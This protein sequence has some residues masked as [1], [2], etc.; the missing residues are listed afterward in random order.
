MSEAAPRLAGVELYFEDLPAATEFYTHVLGLGV[1]EARPNHHARLDTTPAFVCLERKGV[2]DY[3]SADKAVV[4]LEVPDLGAAVERIGRRRFARIA[5][6]GREPWA[7]LP[8][9]EGHTVMLVKRPGDAEEPRLAAWSTSSRVSEY[10]VE[11]IPARLWRATIPGIPT[12]TVRSIAAHLHNARCRWVKTLGSEHGIEA[13]A[14][15]DHR[16]VTP[17]RLGVALRR[18]SRGIADLLRLGARHGGQVPLSRAYVWRNLPLDV[19]HVLTYFVAHEA[20]HRGQIVM[21]AR[22]LGHRLPESV[23]AGL[24]QWQT[25]RRAGRA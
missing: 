13:P 25:R 5:T 6:T 12:R 8:D 21:A 17:R 15:V 24:W 19:E 7:A 23:T 18:S 1:A 3:P 22:Q 16:T 20:H 9:P 4:F 10:L 14:R 2:E 11:R